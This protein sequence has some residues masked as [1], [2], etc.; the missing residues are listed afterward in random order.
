MSKIVIPS[1]DDF[2]LEMG[3]DRMLE[4]ADEANASAVYLDMPDLFDQ[5][6]MTKFVTGITALNV[7]YM[8]AMLRDYHEWL[9]EQL[10]RRSLHLLK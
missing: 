1:F 9:T 8:T 7:K 6:T 2:L 3:K 4:W 10:G 5:A